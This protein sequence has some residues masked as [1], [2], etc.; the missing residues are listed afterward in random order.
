MMGLSGWIH[1]AAWFVKSFIY[2]LITISVMTLFFSIKVCQNNCTNPFPV[3]SA[4]QVYTFKM[5]RILTT[6]DYFGSA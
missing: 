3:Q 4:C 2:L 5:E 1:W 6:I